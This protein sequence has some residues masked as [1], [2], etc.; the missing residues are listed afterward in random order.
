MAYKYTFYK[1]EIGFTVRQK[2]ILILM[3]QSII[4]V[5]LKVNSIAVMM[6]SQ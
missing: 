4:E 1:N 2:L 6:N 3:N 5:L